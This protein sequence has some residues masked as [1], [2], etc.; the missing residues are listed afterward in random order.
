[1]DGK[2]HA[3][4]EILVANFD[5]SGRLA[6]H[7]EKRFV[8]ALDK[9]QLDLARKYG[10]S[11][12]MSYLVKKPGPYQVRMAVHDVRSDHVGTAWQFLNVPDTTKNR[13]ALSGL[14]VAEPPGRDSYPLATPL[15]R[16]FRRG[17]DLVWGSQV[18]NP[19]LKKGSP[20]LEAS[21][22]IFHDGELISEFPPELID[23]KAQKS[24]IAASGSVRLGK[25]MQP[26]DYILQLVVEDQNDGAKTVAQAI[27]IRVIE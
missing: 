10:L 27:D 22:R 13:L 4:F 15:L 1:M 17:H 11:Y 12:S 9:T 6:D 2:Y 24:E 8:A 20:K 7:V 21:L 14:V 3:E 19:K 16:T 5:T 18:L 25:N 26:G 23:A